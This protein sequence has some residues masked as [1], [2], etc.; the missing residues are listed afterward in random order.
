MGAL[1]FKNPLTRQAWQT[2]WLQ[3]QACA[4][5]DGFGAMLSDACQNPPHSPLTT[6][7]VARARTA[8]PQLIRSTRQLDTV[9]S[10]SVALPLIGAGPGLTPSWDD[11]LIG[12][13]CGLRASRGGDR[14]QAWFISQ[15]G[16]AVSRAS[17]KTTTVSRSYI[18]RTINSVGPAWIEDTLVAIAAGDLIRTYSATAQALRVGHTS[19]TDMVLGAILG[20]SVWQ[21][22]IEVN[23]V[24]S[25]LSRAGVPNPTYLRWR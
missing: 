10:L 2:A 22:G 11:L 20:S 1:D 13:L 14:L 15:F 4:S 12:F 9:A 6:I 17:T 23:Q 8:L 5:C 21:D 24:L 3:L 16:S 18:Q 25:V 7:I 19:G